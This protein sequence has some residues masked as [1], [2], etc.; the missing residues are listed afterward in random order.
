MSTP[1]TLDEILA[2]A[3]VADLAAQSDTRLSEMAEHARA[4]ETEVSYLRRLAQGR[5]DILVAEQERRAAGGSI[6]DLIAA[7]PKILAGNE[8]RPPATT[9]RVPIQ[10]AP[11]GDLRWHDGLETLVADDTLANLPVLTDTD[12]AS[13]LV[14]LREFEGELSGTRRKLHGVIDNIELELANRQQHATE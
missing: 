11:E 14:R 3:Y 12:L 8:T 1:I 4:L 2:P 6:G 9:A 7:L 13:A 10:L 5:I